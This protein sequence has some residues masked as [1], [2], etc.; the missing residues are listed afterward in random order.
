MSDQ[1]KNVLRRMIIERC[2]P[3]K[4]G[5][6]RK[7]DIDEAIEIVLDLVQSGIQWRRVKSNSVSY[8]T[9]H[10]HAM[11]WFNAN[12][13][14]DAYTVVLRWYRRFHPAKYYC[15]DSTMTKNQY[16]HDCVGRNPTDRGRK[17]T[18]VSTITDHNGVT[19]SL[20]STPANIPDV[21]LLA[22]TLNNC[23]EN[24][25]RL[26]LFADKGY[27]SR[28]NSRCC[29]SFGLLD[30]I[31]RRKAKTMRRANSKRCVIECSYSWIDKSR[32]LLMR[33]EK[34]VNTYE[35]MMYMVMGHLLC[36]RFK[37]EF[38]TNPL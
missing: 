32:R 36:K 2:G 17:A 35:Q 14:K 10:K 8:V 19:L 26:E 28:S 29:T 4:R 30:R 12:V 6:P 33:F 11:K 5:R 21:S 9:I 27:C 23:M 37:Y 20:L 24:L 1:F 13:V 38:S 34:Y 7:I 15:I 3:Q 22:Q 18:K 25:E 16:G 31:S